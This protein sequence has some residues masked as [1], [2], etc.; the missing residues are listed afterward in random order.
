MP[1]SSSLLRSPWSLVTINAI[2]SFDVDV[3]NKDIEFLPSHGCK[4]FSW[5]MRHMPALCFP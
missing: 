4:I 2:C 1:P 5:D 3:Q